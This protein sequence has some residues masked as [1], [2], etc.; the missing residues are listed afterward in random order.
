MP[1][2][3]PKQNS[4]PRVAVALRPLA[5]SRA[6]IQLPL[7]PPILAGRQSRMSQPVRLSAQEE[8][9]KCVICS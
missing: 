3:F 7:P 2:R 4:D 1:S 8:A 6:T 9:G 5:R